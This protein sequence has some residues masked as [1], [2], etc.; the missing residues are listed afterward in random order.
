MGDEPLG[1]VITPARREFKLNAGQNNHF[2]ITVLVGLDAVREGRTTLNPEFSTSWSPKDVSR[3]AARSR[4]YALKTSL[5]WI[6][7][8]VDV[9]RSSVAKAPGVL[10]DSASATLAELGRSERLRFVAKAV[11]APES[12][13]ELLVR[14][15]IH[16]RNRIVHTESNSRLDA[17]IRAE[18]LKSA[19][20]IHTRHRGLDVSRTID[21]AD[22]GA[23]P[24][25]KDVASI[26][27]AAHAVVQAIDDRVLHCLDVEDYVDGI[28]RRDIGARF[29]AGDRQVFAR[30]W[31]GST[32]KTARRIRQLL[33]Q[34]GFAEA[35]QTCPTVGADYISNLCALKASEARRR[36]APCAVL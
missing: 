11:G 32:D 22:S 6:V 7:D 33:L 1:L 3:S 20:Q 15:A 35:P 12:A 21:L 8:L 4:D 30:M 14:L 36:F 31:P 28:L 2:L 25:F 26:I 17:R 19:E 9:Y 23:S 24:R 34:N 18:L 27:E 13:E 5:A 29:Q 16:W 10:S